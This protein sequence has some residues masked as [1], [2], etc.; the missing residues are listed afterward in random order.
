MAAAY[1]CSALSGRVASRRGDQLGLAQLLVGGV[2]ARTQPRHLDALLAERRL[3]LGVA[4]VQR[5][6]LTQR[7]CQLARGQLL[8]VA[9]LG[10]VRT[11]AG[12]LVLHPPHGAS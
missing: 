9:Q 6:D 8:G 7:A 10:Q 1:A 5:A 4:G 11:N 2:Q 3:K 12:Q